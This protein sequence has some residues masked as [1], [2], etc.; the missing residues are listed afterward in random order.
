MAYKRSPGSRYFTSV[1]SGSDPDDVVARR[2]VLCLLLNNQFV[3]CSYFVNKMNPSAGGRSS[4]EFSISQ[5][6]CIL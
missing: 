4:S 6:M 5:G 1:K 2:S 3:V